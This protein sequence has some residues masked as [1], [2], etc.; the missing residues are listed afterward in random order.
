MGPEKRSHKV[1]EEDRRITAYHEAGH[2][3]LGHVLPL[4]D[5]VHM[6]TVVPRGQAAG[7]TLSLPAKELDHQGKNKLLQKITMILGGRA[8]E[9]L[10]QDDICTGAISDLKHA[11][12]LARSMVTRFG[13][14]DKLGTVYLGSDQEIFVGMEFGQSREYSE[15]TAAIIDEEVRSILNNAYAQAIDLLKE[16]RDK[17]E[18]LAQLLIEKETINHQQFMAFMNGETVNFAENAASEQ[19]SGAE[20]VS[21]EPAEEE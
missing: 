20:E 8:A 6:I 19:H 16:N 5:D 17:L 3:I 1:L 15:S 4:C 14:S 9:S 12:E 2:A 21:D 11:T 10:T 13:M 18:G 7:L